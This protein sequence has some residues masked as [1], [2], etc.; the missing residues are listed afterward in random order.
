MKALTDLLYKEICLLLQQE[1]LKLILLFLQPQE[2]E[3]P[4]LLLML[5][6]F[7]K[8]VKRTAHS[9]RTLTLF[10]RGERSRTEDEAN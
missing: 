6:Q 7:H 3:I 8:Q 10:G 1:K 2:R 4:I 5:L 9:F